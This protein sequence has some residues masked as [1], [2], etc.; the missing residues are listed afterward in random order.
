MLDIYIY[1]VKHLGFR[2]AISA[3]VAGWILQIQFTKNG[4]SC[5]RRPSPNTSHLWQLPSP[6]QLSTSPKPIPSRT[7]TLPGTSRSWFLVASKVPWHFV[8][9]GGEEHWHSVDLHLH[10]YCSKSGVHILVTGNLLAQ[11]VKAHSE[12]RSRTCRLSSLLSSTLPPLDLSASQERYGQP[13]K[14]DNR[15]PLKNLS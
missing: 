1:E 9:T 14:T 2:V 15:V 4:S 5:D 3:I 7:A 12:V 8:R 13:G 6:T 10:R 11:K